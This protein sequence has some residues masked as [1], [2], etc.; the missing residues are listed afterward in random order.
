[1]APNRITGEE[2][3][4]ENLSSLLFSCW[5]TPLVGV[6]IWVRHHQYL[7]YKYVTLTSKP[8]M[9]PTEIC[10]GKRY[11]PPPWN[12]KILEIKHNHQSDG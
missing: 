2:R 6:K 10:L 4:E 8:K 9:D 5:T 1:K 7:R 12:L 11:L 3:V